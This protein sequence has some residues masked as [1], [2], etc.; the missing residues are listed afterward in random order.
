MQKIFSISLSNNEK[1]LL[2]IFF[3]RAV[4]VTLDGVV[5]TAIFVVVVIAVIVADVVTVVVAV[6]ADFVKLLK[7]RAGTSSPDTEDLDWDL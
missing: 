7:L 1:C 5:A 4:T 2:R 6:D 3:Y